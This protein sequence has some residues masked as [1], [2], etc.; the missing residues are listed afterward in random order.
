M[1]AGWVALL[2]LFAGIAIVAWI[3]PGG[4][5]W[6]PVTSGVCAAVCAG[7]LAVWTMRL[8]RRRP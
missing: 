6:V 7:N 5:W 3:D 1:I 8:R 2:V 4:A